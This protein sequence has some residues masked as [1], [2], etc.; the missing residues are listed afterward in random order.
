M[1]MKEK[2]PLSNL[3]GRTGG[4]YY[5]FTIGLY[6]VVTFLGQA[7]MGA[8]ANNKSS[9]Y[10]AVCSTFSGITFLAVV[11]YALFIAKVQPQ[12]V[13]GERFGVKYIPL[14][15]LLACGMFLGLG[16]VNESIARILGGWGL[17]VSPISV[18]LRTP[19]HLIVFSITFALLPAVAEELFFRGIILNS[20][21]ATKKVYAVLV[22]ALCFSLY[23][24]SLTQLVYQ[25]IYG[26]A[27]G[28]LY[29]TA[30]SVLPC[31]IAHFV[32]NFSVAYG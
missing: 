20:L 16:F 4:L 30:K 10:L 29:L 21:S 11:V 6:V 9:A 32:N 17:N 1:R 23:H 14:A 19:W 7:I 8:I 15:I 2:Q 31:I 25:F 12:K 18:P 5:T 26:V 27:L 28:F 3:N 13:V 24:C 22:S